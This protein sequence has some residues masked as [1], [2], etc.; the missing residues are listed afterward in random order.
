MNHTLDIARI[1]LDGGTQPRA[2]IN[3]V[4]IAEY[5]ESLQDGV[6]FPPV[7]VFY[8]GSDY[9][10]A[11]GY[12]RIKAAQQ[13]GLSEFEADVHQG[14][15]R[16]AVLYSV[17]A[18]AQH[19]LR[20]TNA[21][22]RRAVETLLRD[23]EWTAW[24]NREIARRTMV[25]HKLVNTLR[26][27]LSGIKF[28]I[29]RKFERNGKTYEMDTANIG[30]PKEYGPAF[31]GNYTSE[32]AFYRSKAVEVLKDNGVE[33]TQVIKAWVEMERQNPKMFE[34]T[35]QRGHILNLDGTDTPI[36]DA[37]AT[38]VRLAAHEDE[39]ERAKRQLVY[40]EEGRQRK[41]P[42]RLKPL[43]TSDTP[44][45]YTPPEII[46]RTLKALGRITL[47]PCSNDKDNPNVPAEQH[48][49]MADDGL[50][51]SWNG[52][53][54]MNPPYGDEISRWIEK[55]V[56]EYRSGNMQQAVLLLPA[57]TDT[58]WFRKLREFSLCFLY[59]RL[60]FSGADNSAPFP[61]VVVGMGV[62][63]KAF[64]DAFSDIGDVY[65]LARPDDGN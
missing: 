48:F 55:A 40:I 47:D 8:D 12:H 44:E 15:R 61:S 7:T 42:D 1:R 14:T 24:S 26:S 35:V 17:G 58:Q 30:R 50:L 23:D 45:W 46:E 29:E 4:I 36:A 65:R 43:M 63:L 19:G 62:S 60:K 56:S 31:N 34:E 52:T 28:Q 54:Y 51:Q 25:S 38:L 32:E 53:V 16:D 59:G 37:D 64:I 18:N 22:K 5:T 57:R 11:D 33:D 10:L 21:D 6:I 20:R 2:E 41:D 27:E 13:A 3:P 39:Y 9:W 49:T